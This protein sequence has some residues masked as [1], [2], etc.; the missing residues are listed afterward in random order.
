M[1]RRGVSSRTLGA[2]LGAL[3][4]LALGLQTYAG[5]IVFKAHQQTHGEPG[6]VLGPS[7]YLWPWLVATA[8][9]VAFAA[10]AGFLALHLGRMRAAG[11]RERGETLRRIEAQLAA[12]SR[13]AQPSG[14]PAPPAPSLPPESPDGVAGSAGGAGGGP[15]AASGAAGASA[16]GGAPGRGSAPEA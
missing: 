16:A 6:N 15:T 5:W 7:G 12:L 10:L 11:E 3:F 1:T 8:Q 14:A 9:V 2:A 4:L 13:P